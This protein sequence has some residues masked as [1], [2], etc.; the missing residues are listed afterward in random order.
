MAYPIILVL[1][2]FLDVFPAFRKV[3]ASLLLVID[4]DAVDDAILNTIN[5]IYSGQQRY[6]SAV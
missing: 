6:A 5:K 2:L 4:G 1:Q 3:N